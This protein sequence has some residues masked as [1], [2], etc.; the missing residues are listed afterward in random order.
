MSQP[1]RTEVARKLQDLGKSDVLPSHDV[2]DPTMIRRRRVALLNSS[3]E[4]SLRPDCHFTTLTC[5]PAHPEKETSATPG[6]ICT[7][8]VE[9]WSVDNGS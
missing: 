3:W 4:R 2:L 9:Y 6:T 1:T 8:N 5:C 7:R